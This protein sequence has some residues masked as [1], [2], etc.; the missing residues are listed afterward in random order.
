MATY[1]LLEIGQTKPSESAWWQNADPTDASE[2][3]AVVQSLTVYSSETNIDENNRVFQNYFNTK[4]DAETYSATL[5]G[6]STTPSRNAYNVENGIIS[7]IL[8]RDYV[9]ADLPL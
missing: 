4:E 3:T 9:E 8:F 7:T 5:K 2:L 6:L 1:Y